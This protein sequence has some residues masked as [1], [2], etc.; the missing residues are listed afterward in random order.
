MFPL[1]EQKLPYAVLVSEA[2]QEA[3]AST[4]F[5]EKYVRHFNALPVFPL[6]LAIYRMPESVESNYFAK[7]NQLASPRARDLCNLIGKEGLAVYAYYL[8]VPPIRMAHI[9]PAGTLKNGIVD[10]A[11]R[12]RSLREKH[13]FDAKSALENY[14]ALAGRMLALDFFPLSMDSYEIGNC[15]SP[16]NVTIDGGMV[17][18]GSLISFDQIASDRE[19]C[20]IF[21]TTL[22]QLCVTAKLMIHSPLE[23]FL[24]EFNDPSQI[25]MLVS[26]LIWTTIRSEV[27][28][29]VASGLTPD[30][31]LQEMLVLPSYTKVSNVIK[32]IYPERKDWRPSRHDLDGEVNVGYKSIYD[33]H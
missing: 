17:D 6:P 20:S 3:E 25:S 10:A 16:Q 1:K 26:E 4:R 8:P 7:I 30:P 15:T 2:I 18:S 23:P 19:F 12:E 29:C 11:S 33:R 14:L 31:R 32:N 22:S 28:S 27:A 13:K 21:L 5:L 24:W 9:V